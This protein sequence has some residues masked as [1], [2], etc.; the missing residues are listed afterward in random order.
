MAV[1]E[2]ELFHGV[3]LTKLLRGRPTALRLVET[4]AQKDWAAYTIN[5]EVYLYIKHSSTP[6]PR[7]KDVPTW[8]FGFPP[9]DVKKIKEK[10]EKVYFALVCGFKEIKATQM[11]VC[12]L[13]P[14]QLDSLLNQQ[15]EGQQTVTVKAI[16]GKKLRVSSGKTQEPL[17]INK[18]GLEN[19]EIPGA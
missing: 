18:D 1:H 2:F 4:A 14:E 7:E 10:R 11:V 19:W 5:D 15:A 13:N 6:R 3:V 16:S 9:A 8:T 17:K 12:F